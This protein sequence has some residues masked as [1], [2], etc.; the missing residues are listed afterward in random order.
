MR[1][2]TLLGFV[3]AFGFGILLESFLGFGF[4]TGAFFALLGGLLLLCFFL[5]RH[6]IGLENMRGALLLSVC[7]FGLG[8]GVMRFD[9]VDQEPPQWLEANVPAQI[10]MHAK[11]IDEPDRREDNTQL[12]VVIESVKFLGGGTLQKSSSTSSEEEIKMEVKGVNALLFVSRYTDLKYGDEID[13]RG[14]LEKPKNFQTD[15][16]RTFNYVGYLGKDGIRYTMFYPS[17]SLIAEGRGNPVKE[18]LFSLKEHFLA[19]ISRLVPE[20]EASLLGG[21]V[22]GAKHSLGKELLNDFR[23]V[24]VIHIVVLSGYNVTLVADFIMRVFSFL[25][26]TL[27]A[28][29]GGTGII[30]FALLAGGSATVVR[31]SA[32]AIL[33]IFARLTG[34]T[35]DTVRLLFL[36][37]FGMVLWNPKILLFDPSFQLSFMATFG[38][39]VFSP[40]VSRWLSFL[41]EKFSI[42][43]IASATISTQIFV[44]PIILYMMGNVSL[45][46]VPVNL[47]ILI[48]I[49]ATMLLGFLAGVIGFG[50]IPLAVPF[51]YAASL[52]LSYELSVVS[53]AA[54]IP[55]ASFV[56]GAFPWWML[57][58]AYGCYLAVYL[59][60]RKKFSPKEIQKIEPVFSDPPASAAEKIFLKEKSPGM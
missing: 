52:L 8:C 44:L 32:M 9:S 15:G 13:V 42:R 51:A 37:G 45:V 28:A 34:R 2:S 17:V 50:W 31:A 57:P 40:A 41:P 36:V 18:A 25:P 29:F 24:G 11:V 48:F 46:S 35:A 60:Y 6:A 3:L 38:L 58:I 55:G 16:G 19:N 14:K 39:L 5:A 12:R 22:V 21:L 43:E 27:S 30:L 4:F 59:W 54:S 47:A 7:L 26:R 20:P 23:T 1:N 53:S 10:E 33:V 49:P 56:V